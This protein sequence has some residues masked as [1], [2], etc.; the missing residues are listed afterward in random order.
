MFYKIEI[1]ENFEMEPTDWGWKLLQRCQVLT[2]LNCIRTGTEKLVML[3]DI[4][5]V[6][7]VVVNVKI[8]EREHNKY[9]I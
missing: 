3:S 2:S 6:K 1:Q 5:T 7:R 4:K 9:K 8:I